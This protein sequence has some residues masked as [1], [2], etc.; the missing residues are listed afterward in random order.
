MWKGLFRYDVTTS[1]I[2]VFFVAL[3]DALFNIDN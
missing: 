1:E 2:K 3:P